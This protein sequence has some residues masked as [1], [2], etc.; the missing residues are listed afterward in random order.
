[1]PHDSDEDN[2]CQIHEK[3]EKDLMIHDEGPWVMKV[4]SAIGKK[5]HDK[6]LIMKVL[7]SSSKL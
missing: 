3:H 7:M 4:M 2:G 6:T 5:L 1:M